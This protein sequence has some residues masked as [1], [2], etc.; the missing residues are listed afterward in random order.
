[1]SVNKSGMKTGEK[2]LFGIFGLFAVMAVVSYI[3]LEVIRARSDKPMY[4]T[5]THFDFSQ[6]GLRGSEL[7]REAGCTSCHR[8]LRNGTSMGL[9]LDGVGSRRTLQ[10]LV[11]FLKNPEATYTAA[12][13]DHGLAPKEAAYVSALPEQNLHAIAVFLSE[14][15]ADRGSGVARQPPPEKSG[16]I[17]NMLRAWAP[18]G[19][20]TEYRDVRNDPKSSLR[21]SKNGTGTN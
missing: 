12:T 8:A 7:F 16:F 5:T 20:K 1:M 17:D 13:I 11:S 4:V 3:V 2:I 19:W 10:Y 9:N 14:L 15:R 6:E 18:E 21:E